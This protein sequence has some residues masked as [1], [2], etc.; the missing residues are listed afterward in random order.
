MLGTPRSRLFSRLP[1]AWKGGCGQDWPPSNFN[2]LRWVFDRARV[3]QDP[4]LASRTSPHPGTNRPA[5]H[6]SCR[7]HNHSSL[8]SAERLKIKVQWQTVRPSPTFRVL[9][10]R[11]VENRSSAPAAFFRQ[12]RQNATKS[13]QAACKLAPPRHWPA[14]LALPQ[15]ES[16][17]L[18]DIMALF[19]P[20]CPLA[21]PTANAQFGTKMNKIDQWAAPPSPPGFPAKKP[22]KCNVPALPGIY[23]ECGKSRRSNAGRNT[24]SCYRAAPVIIGGF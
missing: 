8:E 18:K 12:M 16:L 17:I 2:G 11:C 1:A 7:S 5:C 24:P 6:P 20:N 23:G 10:S 13:N 15:T 3:L 4:L 9:C 22:F 14:M 19:V 21:N